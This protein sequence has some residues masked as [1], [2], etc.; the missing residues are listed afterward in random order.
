MEADAQRSVFHHGE[1]ADEHACEGGVCVILVCFG[2][3]GWRLRWSDGRMLMERRQRR[4]QI[5]R[6]SG[7]KIHQPAVLQLRETLARPVSLRER[8]SVCEQYYLQH[9]IHINK[10]IKKNSTVISLEE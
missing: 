9:F 8:E 6:C 5:L 7:D 2:D 4:R 3:G 1:L 10:K